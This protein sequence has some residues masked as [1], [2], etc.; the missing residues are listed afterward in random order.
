L[1]ILSRLLKYFRQE[2]PQVRI[3]IRTKK[4]NE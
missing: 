1:P 2:H 4:R 3:T